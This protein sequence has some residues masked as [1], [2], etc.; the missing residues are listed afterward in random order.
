MRRRL[1]ISLLA[2]FL[3]LA[4]PCHA[5]DLATQGAPLRFAQVAVLEGPSAALGR[6]MQLGI[7]AAFEEANRNGGVNGRKV[8]LDS[9]DDGYDPS[10]SVA[11]I[12]KFVDES[13]DLAFVGPVGTPTTLATQPIASDANMAFIAPLSGADFLRAPW[14]GNVVNLRAS[15]AAEIQRLVAY[16]VDERGLQKVGILYQEDAFGREGL[17]ASKAAL[18]ARGLEPV[19]AQS[20]TRDT[21][22]VKTALLRIRK[23]EADA[24]LMVATDRP[25]AEF[26]RVGKEIGFAPVFSCI[27]AV[28]SQALAE[29]LGKDGDGVI[30]SQVVPLPTDDNL[31]IVADYQ[32]ALAALDPEAEPGFISLEGYLAGRIALA[33]AQAAGPWP[34][35]KA[36]M[37]AATGLGALDLGGLKLQFGPGDNQGLDEV[38]L[39]R[40]GPAGDFEILEPVAPGSQS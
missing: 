35:R 11:V 6:G 27:S 4:S 15:Y 32:S 14:V 26:V 1:P 17:T 37:K 16:L 10:R 19:A 8:Q 31:P 21:I 23:A 22:A 36:F 9:A 18:A 3:A 13:V 25:A 38:F 34:S 28:G 7:R 12:R 20:Y 2:P 40:I 39:T 33:A 29:E 5:E 30:V 24:V